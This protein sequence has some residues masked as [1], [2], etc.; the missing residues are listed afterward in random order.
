MQ[1]QEQ[2]GR[3]AGCCHGDPNISSSIP[4]VLLDGSDLGT[5]GAGPIRSVA[6]CET[7]N[8]RGNLES[9]NDYKNKYF[10]RMEINRALAVIKLE[11]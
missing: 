11:D 8:Y 6:H 7:C 5:N 3:G 9:C 4:K 2:G 10:K 1:T